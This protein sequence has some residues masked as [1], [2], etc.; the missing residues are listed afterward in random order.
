M[1]G[2]RPRVLHISRESSSTEAIEGI[3]AR[4]NQQ[5]SPQKSLCPRA[6][7]AVTFVTAPKLKF[8]NYRNLR[9]GLNTD[10]VP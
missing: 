2:T 6:Q 1:T 7:S 4:H 9:L 3:P 10:D 8:R 5:D